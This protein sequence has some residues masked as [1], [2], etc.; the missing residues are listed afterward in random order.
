MVLRQT[1]FLGQMRIDAPLL[2]AAESSVAADFDLAVGTIFAGKQP[3]V[4]R[5]FA[6]TNITPGSPAN[7]IQ[8]VVANSI[9]VYS[10]ATE[11]GSMYS[12]P[13]DRANEVLTSTNSRVTGT[14]TSAA[15]NYVGLDLVR[16]ADTS[17]SDIV[18]FLSATTLLETAKSVPLARTLDYRIIITTTDFSSQSNVIPIAKVVTDSSNNITSV[19]DARQLAFRLAD[20]GDFPNTQSFYPWPGTRFENTSGDVFS[21]GDK[22]IL[23]QKDW[24]DAVM[25]RLWEIGGGER[26]YAATADRNVNLIWV[27]PAFSNGENY[28]WDGTNLHWKGLRFLFDNSTGYNNTVT[29]V[30]VDTPGLTNLADGECIYVDL[31]RTSNATVNAAKAVLSQLGPGSIPG[32]RQVIA[33]RYGANIYTRQWRYPVGTIWVPATTTSQGVVKITRDYLGADTVGAS[34][35]NDPKALSD[36]GGTIFTPLVGNVGLTIRRFDGGA[37]MT[38]W[39][40]AGGTTLLAIDNTGSFAV[41]TGNFFSFKEGATTI[42]TLGT[43][44]AGALTGLYIFPLSGGPSSTGLEYEVGASTFRIVTNV[45]TNFDIKM[46]GTAKWRFSNTGTLTGLEDGIDIPQNKQYKYTTNRTARSKHYAASDFALVDPWGNGTGVNVQ[47]LGQSNPAS[48]TGSWTCSP[49][50]P[51]QAARLLLKAPLNLPHG[52]SITGVTVLTS[53]DGADTIDRDADPFGQVRLNVYRRTFAAGAAT[54]ARLNSTGSVNYNGGD[55][56]QS[57]NEN[58]FS[59]AHTVDNLNT[60]HYELEIDMSASWSW[61]NLVGNIPSIVGGAA[62][63]LLPD[64][65]ILI[66]GG[67]SGGVAVAT[68]RTYDPYTG[69]LTTVTSMNNARAGHKLA[70][71][72]TSLQGLKVIAFGGHNGDG[73]TR[74]QTCEIYDAE[75]NSW[76][77]LSGSMTNAVGFQWIMHPR[78]DTIIAVGG[79][80]AGQETTTVSIND[81]GVTALTSTNSSRVGGALAW[82]NQHGSTDKVFLGVFG[83]GANFA[84]ATNTWESYDPYANT[85]TTGTGTMTASRVQAVA[86]T[87]PSGDVVIAGGAASA[88]AEKAVAASATSQN[89]SALT[90]P[91]VNFVAGGSFMLPDYSIL[92]YAGT[93]GVFPQLFT[94]RGTGG[95]W[96]RLEAVNVSENFYVSTTGVDAN[97]GQAIMLPTGEAVSVAQ[98]AITHMMPGSLHTRLATKIPTV[99]FHGLRVNYDY[100]EVNVEM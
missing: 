39:Q 22:A 63:A 97:A 91:P 55:G 4:V 28:E 17:T 52:A 84:S 77:N 92:F 96:S 11:A 16:A 64:G 19:T 21:G 25:T 66:T 99:R 29:D 90:A 85:W 40:T 89:F 42:A 24:Q 54:I 45:V 86:Q 30:T 46:S 13:A 88:S 62:M 48:R 100:S 1:N 53:G 47:L 75:A 79:S 26:W 60:S 78:G 68:A 8:M 65:R 35:A 2:R 32:A 93:S 98:A 5:G 94:E 6:L 43:S 70:T 14:F 44:A 37:D 23:S 12:A 34:G 38:R 49:R 9:L 83:G 31:D 58:T 80:T 3:L 50:Y 33:W 72:R 76:T 81:T 10:G 41:T 20:G 73:S 57:L 67:Y 15:T 51:G 27:P 87:L 59:F 71:I 36:R 7:A 56:S 18:Q 74:V 95:S 69:R 61:T 82:F